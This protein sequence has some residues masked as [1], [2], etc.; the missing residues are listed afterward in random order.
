MS[1]NMMVSLSTGRHVITTGEDAEKFDSPQE[2]ID[3]YNASIQ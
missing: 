1:D 2:A 3:A